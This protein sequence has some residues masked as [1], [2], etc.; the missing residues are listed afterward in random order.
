MSAGATHVPIP[1]K[2]PRRRRAPAR[3]IP[4]LPEDQP[5]LTWRLV[6]GVAVGGVL[7]GLL[8]R[9]LA[10]NPNVD[11][12]R[13]PGYFLHPT[14]LGGVGM[15]LSLTALGMLIGVVGG[16]ALA[17]M[18]GSGDRLLGGV[19]TTYMWFFRGTPLLVQ[20]IFWY[21]L[22]S[23]YPQLGLRL[24]FL[25]GW[26]PVET[27]GLMGAFLAG[28][29]ALGLNEAAYMAEIVRGGFNTIPASQVEGAQALGMPSGLIYRRV[30]VPQM[31]RVAIPPTTNQTVGMLKMS[32]LVSVVSLPDLLYSAHVIYSRTFETLLL[33]FVASLWYLLLVGAL[34]VL[35]K[36]AEKRASRWL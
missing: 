16:A 4:V 10:L 20:L 6:A 30:L 35:Q 27:A 23:L 17:A 36:L 32:A 29:L 9:S 22:A 1:V 5:R 7:L 18:R 3:R 31:V 14:I 34:S 19:A 21:N 24:P 8:V 13:F 33:L 25:P 11:W 2:A 28:V 15:T 26:Y 12:G